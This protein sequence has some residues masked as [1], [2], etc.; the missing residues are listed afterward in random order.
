MSAAAL[1]IFYVFASLATLSLLLPIGAGLA[2]RTKLDTARLWF[3]GYLLLE[4]LL[5][6]VSFVL[7]RFRINN[8]LVAHLGVPLETALILLAFA[9]WQVDAGARRLFSA[10]V[11]LSGCFWVPL[12][13][14]WEAPNQFSIGLESLQAVLCLAAATYTVVRRA[15]ASTG[16]PQEEAWYW[17]GGG[18]MLYTGTWALMNPLNHYLVERAPEVAVAVL[19][20]RAGAQVGANLLYFRGMRCPTSPSSSGFSTPPQP[21]WRAFS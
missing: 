14:G 19:T 9:A 8:H 12:L 11:P 3:L 17:I 7:G 21:R 13:L 10:L 6:T 2:G 5:E 1:G 20:V 16:L 15:I 4:L 18:V